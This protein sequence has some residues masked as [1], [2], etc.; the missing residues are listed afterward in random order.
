MSAVPSSSPRQT[1]CRA[2]AKEKDEG[3]EERKGWPMAESTV[4][5]IFIQ[6]SA[7]GQCL[8]GDSACPFRELAWA[9]TARATVLSPATAERA[10]LHTCCRARSPESNHDRTGRPL[11]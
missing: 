8:S 5:C 11:R 2:E 4:N 3:D 9:R 1:L 10:I 7:D 6:Y